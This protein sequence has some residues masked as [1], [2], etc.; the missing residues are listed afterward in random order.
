MVSVSE[1]APDFTLEGVED[2]EIRT[3]TLSEAVRDQPAV[4]AFYVHDFN[5]VCTD[6]ICEVDDMEFLTFNDEAA[7][8]GISTD[9]P[10]SHRRFAAE[11]DVS[12][13][14]LSDST[15]AVYESYGLLDDAADP[16]A[17]PKRGIFV[18]D[19]DRTVRYRWTAEEFLDPWETTPLGN[20]NEVVRELVGA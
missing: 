3:F 10:Y 4:L 20:A 9:S 11:N 16:E 14:L 8:F 13:P 19:G 15:R 18:V 5:P 6:Q 7:V 2:G 17:T 1:R 12:Y